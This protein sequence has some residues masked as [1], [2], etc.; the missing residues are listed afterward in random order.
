[1]KKLKTKI[2]GLLVLM[3]L[4]QSSCIL[5]LPYQLAEQSMSIHSDIIGLKQPVNGSLGYCSIFDYHFK[6]I[7]RSHSWTFNGIS[8]K[9]LDA[10]QKTFYETVQSKLAVDCR[11]DT[12][13]KNF[14]IAKYGP[15]NPRF[16]KSYHFTI[17]QNYAKIYDEQDSNNIWRMNKGTLD[18]LN[19][20]FTCD[21]YLTGKINL[22]CVDDS[23]IK[24]KT[25]IQP[26]LFLV[27]YNKHG[28]KVWSKL[29][30]R[31]YDDIYNN[32]N[33]NELYYM[34]IKQLINDCK[35]EINND[36]SFKSAEEVKK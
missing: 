4:S 18:F 21:Y 19:K 12:I 28:Y 36:L 5:D 26:W 7:P 33:A 11:Y 13:S 34:V 9:N 15:N 3:I 20:Y 23:K 14:N 8:M 10:L 16:L 30:K 32:Q 27:L 22:N 29:Y 31:E 24:N 2:K 6:C 35:E 25:I 1:V 17:P